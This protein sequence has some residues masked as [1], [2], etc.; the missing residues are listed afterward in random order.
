MSQPSAGGKKSRIVVDVAQIEAE[1]RARR[2]GRGR[3]GGRA[4][5]A[6]P[7][8]TLIVAGALV[9]VSLGG[10]MWW[11]SFKSGPS[12]SL[13]LLVDA[14]RRDDTQ[15]IEALIDADRVAQGFVPQVIENLT[16]ADS[17]VVPAHM[18]GRIAEVLPRLIPR[19]R[20]NITRE[21]AD[22]L[23]GAASGVTAELPLPLMALGIARAAE[24]EERGDTAN[25]LLRRDER[26]VALTMQRDGERWKV[27]SLK[28]EQLAA[29]LAARLAS[30]LST[31]PAQQQP[32]PPSR[33]NGGR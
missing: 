33:R 25:V 18:R 30:N 12:Y 2:G 10:Y 8:G 13:A 26:T 3:G 4:R 23:K 31:S 16:G 22:A 7:V 21:V 32:P 20:E 6:L 29:S 24:V 9:L 11:R 19:V 28:D 1:E 15:A 14:A 27:V 5:R 17:S